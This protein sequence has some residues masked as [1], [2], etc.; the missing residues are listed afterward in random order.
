VQN[1]SQGHPIRPLQ[2]LLRAHG[3]SRRNV[4]PGYGS[5]CQSVSKSKGMSD[6]ERPD[7]V[8]SNNSSEKRKLWRRCSRCPVHIR[9]PLCQ[10][11]ARTNAFERQTLK[12]QAPSSAGS[13]ADKPIAIN[14]VDVEQPIFSTL[15]TKEG[16]EHFHSGVIVANSMSQALGERYN[17]V[18]AT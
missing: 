7:V 16:R 4:R 3:H 5:C 13:I 11:A 10:T 15:A 2:F 1:G 12:A 17:T 8:G 18:D 6:N 14:A 9:Q